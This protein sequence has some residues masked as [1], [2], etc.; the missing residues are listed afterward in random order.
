MLWRNS[1]S[2]LSFFPNGSFEQFAT[3]FFFVVAPWWNSFGLGEDVSAPVTK[4]ERSDMVEVIDDIRSDGASAR[5]TAAASLSTRYDIA[6]CHVHLV[7]FLQ[8]TDGLHTLM[9]AL[10]RA[11]VK[12]C[13]ISGMPLVVT[14]TDDAPIR[15]TYY[16]DSDTSCYWYS[17][18]DV[19]VARE[20]MKLSEDDRRRFHPFICGFNPTDRNAVDHVKRMIEW[21]PGLWKGIGEVM[22]R[23][24]DLS[25]L[26][27][28]ERGR[29]NH[30]AL[31]PIYELAAELSLPVSIHSNISSVWKRDPIYL[32]ELKHSLSAHP[33]TQFIWCH[34]GVSRRVEVHDITQVI[35]DMLLDHDNLAID[36]SW[37]VYDT[38]LVKDGQANPAWVT[39]VNTFPDRFMIGSDVVG[40]FERYD[41]EIQRY[42]IFLDALEPGTARK[43][44]RDNF[45]RLL[46]AKGATLSQQEPAVP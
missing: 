38:H 32:K 33:K 29:A 31:D 17:A 19:L 15:P 23:H 40:K 5:E 3:I 46:P 9:K 18:T 41:S 34:A 37:I 20:L 13:M 14:W 35:S 21:F 30:L 16:L 22:T 6:D 8:Q 44:A 43:V 26:I 2:G 10:D 1:P 12:E 24:D 27:P 7:D 25:N 11:G 4:L 28:G 42:G 39:L 36:L 45:L